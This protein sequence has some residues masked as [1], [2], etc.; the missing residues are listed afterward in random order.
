MSR[1]AQD[2]EY[3][4]REASEASTIQGDTNSTKNAATVVMG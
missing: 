1:Q 3:P 4:H 2:A